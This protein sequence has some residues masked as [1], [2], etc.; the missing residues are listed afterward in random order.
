MTLLP[1]EPGSRHTNQLASKIGIPSN[2]L[3]DSGN[4]LLDWPN[5]LVSRLLMEKL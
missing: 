2:N 4:N 5:N 3:L 1:V